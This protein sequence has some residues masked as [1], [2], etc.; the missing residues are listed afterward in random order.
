MPVCKSRPRCQEYW[1]LCSLAANAMQIH[2]INN[3]E[4]AL[5]MR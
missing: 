5:A 3:K 1:R 4:S 2:G